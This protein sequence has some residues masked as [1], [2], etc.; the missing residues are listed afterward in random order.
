MHKVK[1]E[2]NS[3]SPIKPALILR[4]ITFPAEK[5][6]RIVGCFRRHKVHFSVHRINGLRD[7]QYT[8]PFLQKWNTRK[9]SINQTR[10]FA[11]HSWHK[12][13]LKKNVPNLWHKRQPGQNIENAFKVVWHG[14]V[15]DSI[16]EHNL[17][18]AQ[19][20]IGRV[21]LLAQELVQSVCT[22]QNHMRIFHLKSTLCFTSIYHDD[23]LFN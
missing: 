4:L 6:T 8:A 17:R 11:K 1:R 12:N 15:G 16:G 18:T 3:N 13:G 19:L 5:P 20:I 7:G 10:K 21:N 14:D 22:G 2:S 23:S 9:Q